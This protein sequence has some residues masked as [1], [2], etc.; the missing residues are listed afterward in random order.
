LCAVQCVCGSVCVPFSKC[1]VQYVCGS[2][3]V[4]FS[5][6]AV[7][8]MFGSVCVPFSVCAVQCVCSSVCVPFSMR[9]VTVCC[10][11]QSY[12]QHSPCHCYSRLLQRRQ[13]SIPARQM[14]MGK[15]CVPAL[16]FSP[17]S[18]VLPLLRT[19]VRRTN[20]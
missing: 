17:V 4:R 6:C 13:G 12:R 1:A 15:V 19:F 8:C 5:M 7:Q 10:Q 2:V 16:R 9:T 11:S 20:S 14:A 18:T 3:C